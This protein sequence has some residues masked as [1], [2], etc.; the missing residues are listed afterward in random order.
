MSSQP[1]A[2]VTDGAKSIPLSALSPDAWTPTD[3]YETGASG[4]SVR[5]GQTRVP[6]LYR[7]I[8]IRAKAVASMPFRLERNGQDVTD[9]D[10][11]KPLI[12]RLR[13]LLY[14]TESSL[15]C[16]NAAYWE[17]GTNL[18]GRNVTPF[19]LATPTIKPDIDTTAANP[20]QALRGFWRTGGRGGYLQPKQVAYFWGPSIAVELGPDLAMA[21]VAVTLAAAGLLHYLDIFATSFFKRGAVKVTLLTV[22]GNPKPGETEKLD[23]WWKRMV[24]GARNAFGSVVVRASVKPQVIGS[25]VNETMAPQLTKLSREDV[26]IGMGV[27]LSL[28]FSNALAGGTADAERKNF[29]DFTVVPECESV[30]DEPLNNLY[31]TRLGFRLIWTPEK[32]E[33]YQASELNKA[34][35]LTQLV[36]QPIMLVDEARERLEL[37]PLAQVQAQTPS[38]PSPPQLTDNSA[39]PALP[40]PADESAGS[41]ILLP[42]TMDALKL[43]QRKAIK[44]LR[45]GKSPA[46]DFKSAAIDADEHALIYHALQHATTESEVKAAFTPGE[47]LSDAERALYERVR[48]VLAQ[49]GDAAVR[50]IQ[51]S[52]QPDV[53]ALSV[54]IRAALLP[55]LTSVVNET[56]AELTAAVGIS[57]DAAAAGAD[58]AG[59][60]VST[61]LSGME[62]TTRAAV[63]RVVNM[64][65]Q[66]PGMRREDLINILQGAF[67]P[68]R[69]ELI[70]VTSLTEAN[71][72]AVASYKQLLKDTGISMVMVWQTSNDER[73][74]ILC[75]PL[76]GKTED[77][78]GEIGPPPRHLRCRCGVTLR[79]V[80]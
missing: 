64:H 43:W 38:P 51:A 20:Q 57:F 35:S 65:R 63:E 2:Y 42:G 46:Y 53:G 30:I 47:G 23:A 56:L 12:K 54:A 55:A 61:W 73:T 24:A 49:A 29:Y 44:R 58:I 36:Q 15:C 14:L 7:A 34:Q 32:L 72:H 4:L 70:A 18:A 26:A 68:R 74:C 9:D 71:A 31:L 78:W 21:P 41:S 59:A 45:D 67:G 60:Y 66:T 52:Q 1:L 79:H 16:Y 50:A 40:A 25:S 69:A 33:V 13:A 39:P 19:W 17:I 11:I 80:K 75:G 22:D 27:P 6:T 48:S 3:E 8:D 10:D 37:P 28:L 76:N 77:Q 62:K 5:T